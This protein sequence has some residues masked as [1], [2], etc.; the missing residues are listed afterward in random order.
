M[1]TPIRAAAAPSPIYKEVIAAKGSSGSVPFERLVEIARRGSRDQLEGIMTL[2]HNLW[3]NQAAVRVASELGVLPTDGG[4]GLGGLTATSYRADPTSTGNDGTM[5]RKEALSAL[6]STPGKVPLAMRLA[7]AAEQ[8]D[9]EHDASINESQVGA[10]EGTSAM[11]QP[12]S[13]KRVD[14]TT[15][16]LD[17]MQRGFAAA[18]LESSWA[19]VRAA[20]KSA[21]RGNKLSGVHLQ[22]AL[23]S[24]L[25]WL[26]VWVSPLDLSRSEEVPDRELGRTFFGVNV[27]SKVHNYGRP[28]HGRGDEAQQHLEHIPFGILAMNAADHL[29]MVVRGVVYE[30][31]VSEGNDSREVIATT[32]LA[33]YFE[34]SRGGVLVVPPEFAPNGDFDGGVAQSDPY[35]NLSR[36]DR[37]QR[38]LPSRRLMVDKKIEKQTKREDAIARRRRR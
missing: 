9:V 34:K 5:Q 31:H 25:G 6:L 37:A 27:D 3:G 11:K 32:P 13:A 21:Q 24:E 26:G 8:M 35:A 36:F 20:T 10:F 1:A 14:C 7:A 2:I 29:A 19:Q 17:V 12:G 16:I 4:A 33:T 38:R 22:Q 18:G 30:A 23:Q 28:G 15:Y